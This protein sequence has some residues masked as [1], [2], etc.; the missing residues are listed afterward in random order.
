[1]STVLRFLA[2]L[3]LAGLMATGCGSPQASPPIIA[4]SEPVAAAAPTTPS[5]APAPAQPVAR[6]TYEIVRQ[7]PHDTA[8]FT[9][10]LFFLDGTLFESTGRYGESQLRK[11]D[12]DTGNVLIT[13]DLP[14]SVFGEGS[15]HWNGRMIVLTW[16]AG[17]GFIIDPDTLEI[18]SSFSYPGEGW[19]LTAS[20]T[21]LIKS[22]GSDQLLFLDP[23][24]FK[25]TKRVRVTLNGNAL[26]KLNELEWING[27]V[28]ANV[29]QADQ[30]VRIDPE[31]GHVVGVIDL[32]GLFPAADRDAPLDDVLNGIA[33]D[34][35]TDRL[36]VTGKHWPNL[37]ELRIVDN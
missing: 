12:P 11:L 17:T 14:A 37:F 20:D 16:K 15:A 31:S 2:S 6:Q 33:Y 8:A 30:I 1:M 7:M 28:W 3:G 35:T 21:H 25:I 32:T 18:A 22:N 13:K 26:R 29:W 36:F 27:E 34:A 23:D 19:G 10:G 4:P 9:Q 5:P 24:T